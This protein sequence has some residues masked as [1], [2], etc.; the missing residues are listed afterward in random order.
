MYGSA[1]PRP[2]LTFMPKRLPGDKYRGLMAVLLTLLVLRK[3][4]VSIRSVHTH[5]VYLKA[6]VKYGL[7]DEPAQSTVTDHLRELSA[8]AGVPVV[9]ANGN[10]PARCLTPAAVAGLRAFRPRLKRLVAAA[11]VLDDYE[12]ARAGRAPLTCP[13]AHT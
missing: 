5:R 2:A 6:R 8:Q 3:E 13:R 1:P 9:A 10:G 12:R 7:P 4:P 11:K